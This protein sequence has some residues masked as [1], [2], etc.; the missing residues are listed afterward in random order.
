MQKFPAPAFVVTTRLEFAPGAAGDRAGLIVFGYSYAWLGLRQTADGV[1]LV[2]VVCAKANEGGV[3]RESASIALP[4]GPLH[5]RVA[6][7]AQAR[8]QFAYSLDGRNFENLGETF[9][10]EPSRWV[11]AKV[12]LFAT[13]RPGAPSAGHA[14]FA[15]FRVAATP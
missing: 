6:V 15:A 12:G 7:D 3:E 8:C 9:Q 5:L 10:A 14:D 11:G 13:S 4:A 2:Q 1:R